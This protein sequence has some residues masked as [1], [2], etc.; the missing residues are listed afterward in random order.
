MET[1]AFVPEI[2]VKMGSCLEA[3]EYDTLVRREPLAEFET[4]YY[5]RIHIEVPLLPEAVRI[6]Q[7]PLS[8]ARAS[9]NSDK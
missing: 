7:G 5:K 3:K 8:Y 2:Q 6:K 1:L 9:R 4:G